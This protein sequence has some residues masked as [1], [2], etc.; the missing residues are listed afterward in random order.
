MELIIEVVNRSHRVIERHRLH[1]EEISIGRAYDNDLILSDPHVSPYHGLLR[2]NNHGTWILTDRESLNGIY[3]KR[4]RRISDPLA[5]KSGD[6]FIL[7]KVRLRLCQLD[8]P[9]AAT[10]SLSTADTLFNRLSKPSFFILLL[11]LSLGMVAANEYL[12]SSSEIKAN[13]MALAMVDEMMSP[14]LWAAFW[15]FVGRLVRHDSRFVT[16]CVIALCGLN[17]MIINGYLSAAVGFNTQSE[18]WVTLY[19]NVTEGLLLV[20]LFTLSLRFAVQQTTWRRRLTANAFAWSIV[21]VSLLSVQVVEEYFE[22][23]PSYQKTLLPGVLLWA[24]PVDQE[25]FVS[26]AGTIFSA[27]SKLAEEKEN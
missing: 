2:Y 23:Y 12:Q 8:H 24:E 13:A 25:T 11:L 19:N 10:Q 26:R 4:H 15:G 17:L 1:G 22:E 27:A 5:L 20:V 21:G 18:S 9:V 3:S 7:G 14:L 16:Q 6:E